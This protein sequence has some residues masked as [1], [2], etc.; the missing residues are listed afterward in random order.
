MRY[1]PATIQSGVSSASIVLTGI[2]GNISHLIF[3]VRPS[4]SLANDN[5]FAFTA[6]SNFSILDATSTNVTGG[7]AISHSQAM[8]VLNREWCQSTYTAE[9]ALGTG[10]NNNANVY[11][12]CFCTD[13]VG[14]MQS[15]TGSG[16]MKFVGSEQLQIQFASA[17]GAS[18]QVDIFAYNESVLEV[19]AK[20]VNKRNYLY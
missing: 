10:T 13:P 12:Y 2:N 8:P 7:V 20:S 15:G 9:I 11:Q 18:T 19:G 3:V 1:M 17:L 6:I 4:A 14:L 5:A 16:C